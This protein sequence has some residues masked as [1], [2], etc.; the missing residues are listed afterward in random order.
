ML[1]INDYSITIYTL[2]KSLI[3]QYNA[4][5]SVIDNNKVIINYK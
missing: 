4:F 5:N 3:I 2:I 1:S